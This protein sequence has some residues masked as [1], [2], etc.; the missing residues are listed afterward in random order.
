MSENEQT[1]PLLNVGRPLR[2]KDKTSFFPA[3]PRV[4][5]VKGHSHSS[6]AKSKM[7]PYYFGSEH[8][9]S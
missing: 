4:A 2:L 8:H 1:P 5:V 7:E 6:M 3:M 9:E